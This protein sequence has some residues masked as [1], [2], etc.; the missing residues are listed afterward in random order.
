LQNGC[1]HV[2]LLQIFTLISLIL[3]GA[4]GICRLKQ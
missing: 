2:H 1:S 4:M 3:V